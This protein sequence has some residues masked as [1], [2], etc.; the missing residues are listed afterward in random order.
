[1][2]DIFNKMDPTYI[3]NGKF[4]RTRQT[5]SNTIYQV[6]LLLFCFSLRKLSSYQ[7]HVQQAKSLSK[8]FPL[9]VAS[10]KAT[11]DWN[12][13]PPTEWLTNG[14]DTRATSIAKE[15]GWWHGYATLN[16]RWMVCPP[17]QWPDKAHKCYLLDLIKYTLVTPEL[18]VNFKGTHLTCD[19]K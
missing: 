6:A 12:Y 18:Q 2:A 11:L 8:T 10:L 9:K 17:G 7:P 14:V 3:L 13:D 1:M 19:V 4:D 5:C 16:C 15:P